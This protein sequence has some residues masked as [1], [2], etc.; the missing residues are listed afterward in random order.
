MVLSKRSERKTV[1]LLTAPVSADDDDGGIV[2]PVLANSSADELGPGQP[3]VESEDSDS[4]ES[5]IQA[6][7]TATIFDKLSNQSATINKSTNGTGKTVQDGS[8]SVPHPPSY[9]TK[10]ITFINS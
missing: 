2:L 8:S 9:Q 10:L 6:K 7:D 1:R 4:D 5:E 3:S